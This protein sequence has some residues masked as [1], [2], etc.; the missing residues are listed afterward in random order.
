MIKKSKPRHSEV[1]RKFCREEA[2][3]DNFCSVRYYLLH[4]PYKFFYSKFYFC[5][6]CKNCPQIFLCHNRI[7]TGM[8]S[9]PDDFSQAYIAGDIANRHQNELK[10]T[11][12][13]LIKITH[14]WVKS[15]TNKFNKELK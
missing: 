11:A 12:P 2:T 8:T 14:E 6:T 5:F 7:N 10:E 3:K 4:Y 15:K 13:E 1:Y 9:K